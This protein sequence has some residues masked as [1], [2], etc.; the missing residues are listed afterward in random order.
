MIRIRTGA[1]WR[2]DPALRAALRR[3]AGPARDAAARAVVDALAIEVDGIDISAG[4]AE[5]PL[6]PS[7]EA[8]L[9]AV[10]RVVGGAPHATL[11]FPDGEAEVLLRRRGPAVLLTVVSV[12]RPSRVLASDVEV[13]AEELAAAALEAC[14]SFCRELAE[15]LPEAATREA[16][17]LQDAARDLR[18]VEPGPAPVPPPPAATRPPRA[19]SRP[20]RIV[21]AV[22][23]GE[24]D[25]LLAA[26]EGGRPDLGSLLLPGHVVL[27]GVDG[28]EICSVPGLPFLALRDLGAACDGL[29]AAA[30]RGEPRYGIPLARPG[31]SA[32]GELAVD[33]AQGTVA[34]P[35]RAPVPCRALDL[36]RALA[37]A[38]VEFGRVAR[39]RNPRQA[40]NANLSELEAS[41][42]DRLAQI[43]E[44]AEGDRAGPAS[45]AGRAPSP[46]ALPQRA[47]GPGR[48]R[49]LSFRRTFSVDVGTPA[50]DGLLLAGGVVVAAGSRAVAAVERA[51]G[52][53]LWR[54]GGCELAAALPGALLVV[55]GGMVAALALRSG[56]ELWRRAVP[57]AAPSG[58]VALARGPIIL[59]E[60]GALTGLDRATGRTLWRVEPPGAARLRAT[61]FGG[62]AAAAADT[63]F[64]YGVDAEGRIAWRLR[65]PGPLERAPSPAAGL[66]L[67]L[68]VRDAG[69]FLLAV[70]P[71][72]GARAWEAPLD[73]APAGAP[74]AWGRRIVVAGSIAG[75]PAVTVLD[76]GGAP[77]W[78]D[79][80]PLLSGAPRLAVA[81]ETLVARDPRGA[82]AALAHDGAVRWSRPAR[83]DHLA[84]GA[85]APAV[86]RGT[87][88]VPAG[89]GIAALDARTGEI[90]GAI[91]G[92]S[93]VRLEVDAAL[94]VAAM[95]EDGVAT[96][97]KV[98]THLS[99]V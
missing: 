14:A 57:G 20:G 80:P 33:L 93:P 5:G 78:T 77:V 9:R 98:A 76:R 1:S 30:R 45:A 58:A 17:R 25:G 84:P 68:A 11:A 41:A 51:T 60:P 62:V 86:A 6:L 19:P 36:A 92:A 2:H 35:G 38:A 10:A 31:R 43:E 28:A 55:R 21:C 99:V 96:G 3:A 26:Y 34:A 54:A 15:I 46:R 22:E 27:R 16:R 39:A 7:L 49:R 90:V 73:F 81:G 87:V 52:A 85:A 89:D 63:G 72:S 18:R 12:S 65:A 32:P 75:D 91:H 97:W 29:I 40:E 8:L 44:L 66:C 53:P 4:R 88:L 48:L 70:D 37:E 23:L 67:A 24:D 82:V 94:G 69:A 47:L 61:A 59:A 71:A 74:L 79:A 50:G 42:A 64:L 83:S 95:D 13:D 56:A